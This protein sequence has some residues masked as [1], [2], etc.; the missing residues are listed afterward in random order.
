MERHIERAWWRP[1]EWPN[2]PGG[3]AEPEAVPMCDAAWM[4]RDVW[5]SA[6]MLRR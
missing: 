4:V 1:H 3:E 6:I 5:A 2:L